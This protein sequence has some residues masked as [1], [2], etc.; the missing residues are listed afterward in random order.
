MQ[1]L[2]GSPKM[3]VEEIIQWGLENGYCFLPLH[4]NSPTAHHHINN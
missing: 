1:F 2:E 4:Y 3:T